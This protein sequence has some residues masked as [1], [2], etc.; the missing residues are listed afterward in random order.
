M[1]NTYVETCEKY[2][3]HNNIDPW[4]IL[5]LNRHGNLTET[6]LK[7]AYKER[8]L[9]LH[10]DKGGDAVQFANLN[11]CYKYLYE[12]LGI[13]EPVR[14]S[15][16]I[17]LASS[18]TRKRPHAQGSLAQLRN[19]A[20]LE[21]STVLEVNGYSAPPKGCELQRWQDLKAACCP[22]MFDPTQTEYVRFTEV[23]G[24]PKF[25][26]T[27]LTDDWNPNAWRNPQAAENASYKSGLISRAEIE[28]FHRPE[29]SIPQKYR[30][31]IRDDWRQVSRLKDE[32][33]EEHKFAAQWFDS[34]I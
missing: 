12:T 3:R 4:T 32:V 14:E 16:K 1:T 27:I 28:Q 24:Q 30:G 31:S 17:P 33:N 21:H 15:C 7:N 6:K 23:N 5:N 10:P 29:V 2:F 22:D 8:A 26:A 34:R 20:P 25:R 13:H 18:V 11:T 9:A 19:A